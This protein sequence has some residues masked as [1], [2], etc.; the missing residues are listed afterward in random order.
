MMYPRCRQRMHALKDST[1]KS[2]EN[3]KSLLA[4]QFITKTASIAE[5]A[6]ITV[7]ILKKKY[8]MTA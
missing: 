4:K 2:P 8:A 5:D 6:T 7:R 3:A 1:V